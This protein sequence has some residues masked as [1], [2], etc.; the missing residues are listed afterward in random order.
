M[1]IELREE[2]HWCFEV[3]VPARKSVIVFH[4]AL[5]QHDVPTSSTAFE[6]FSF[7]PPPSSSLKNKMIATKKELLNS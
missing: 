7:P 4:V 2:E 5:A 3:F 1:K 6:L